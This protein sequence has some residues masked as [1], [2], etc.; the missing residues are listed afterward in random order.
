MWTSRLLIESKD[1]I[2]IVIKAGIHEVRHK[3]PKDLDKSKEE[4]LRQY[5]DS[6]VP[7]LLKE[8]TNKRKKNPKKCVNGSTNHL[9]LCSEET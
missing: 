3:L 1:N 7:G 9:Q 6:V 5:F 4:N 2:Y 8:L